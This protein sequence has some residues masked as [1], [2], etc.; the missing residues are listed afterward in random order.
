MIQIFKELQKETGN[1]KFIKTVDGENP[2]H[3]YYEFD[4]NF[5][6]ELILATK[7]YRKLRLEELSKLKDDR[8]AYSTV[9][10]KGMITRVRDKDI[11]VISSMALTG[12]IY[13]FENGSLDME[14]IEFLELAELVNLKRTEIIKW[15]IELENRINDM[16]LIDLYYLNVRAR[17][18][19]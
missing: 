6:L 19:Q 16:E 14:R 5:D 10:Y 9:E 8:F 4:G 18:V 15:K 13:Q 1:I 3:Y 7:Q 17:P 2:Q 11:G 12:G